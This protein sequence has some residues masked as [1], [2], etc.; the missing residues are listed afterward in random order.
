MVI[1]LADNADNCP[2]VANADQVNT[3]GLADGGNACDT[4]D[5]EDGVADTSDDLPFECEAFLL[6]PIKQRKGC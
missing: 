3:D 2:A 4:D 6:L 5:D 1:R